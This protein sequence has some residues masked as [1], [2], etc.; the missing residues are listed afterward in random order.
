[1]EKFSLKL[2]NSVHGKQKFYKLIQDDFCP[3]DAFQDE[4]ENSNYLSEL[5][6]I[7]AYMDMIANLK[8][9]PNTK[10]R[11]I[12]P[13]KS[14]AKEY[15]IKS[16]HLRIYLFHE[17]K[18]GKIIVCGGY[19]TSQKSDIRYFRNLKKAYLESL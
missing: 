1:M 13:T 19:K 4:I 18:T 5:R 9:L 14:L 16:K 12:S 17:E 11:D 3:F 15:E 7:Y 2:I 8:T 10:F 6:T